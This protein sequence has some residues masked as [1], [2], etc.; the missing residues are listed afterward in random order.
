MVLYAFF[1]IDVKVFKYS[2]YASV[3][4]ILHDNTIT[5]QNHFLKNCIFKVKVKI[6]LFT[7][8]VSNMFLK[9][10]ASSAADY[11]KVDEGPEP[12]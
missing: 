12:W 6:V 10:D 4:F 9:L 11:G 3:F 1:M 2:K 7:P 8:L 5:A